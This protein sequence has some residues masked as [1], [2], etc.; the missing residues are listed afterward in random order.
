MTIRDYIVAYNETFRYVEQKY[1]PDALKSLFAA[2]SAQWCV[3]LDGVGRGGLEGCMEYWGGDTG[4]LDREQAACRIALRDEVFTIEMNE[5]PSVKELRERGREPHMGTLT[6]CGHCRAL[7]EPVLNRHGLTFEVD[8][9]Y[10]EDGNCG[11]VR[12]RRKKT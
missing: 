8:I 2:I 7:Y 12:H 10:R 6:Y 5:C 3:H 11:K 1:G 9:A 4:T